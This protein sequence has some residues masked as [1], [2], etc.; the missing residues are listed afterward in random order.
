MKLHKKLKRATGITILDLT[1]RFVQHLAKKYYFPPHS[2]NLPKLAESRL[3]F[4]TS[5]KGLSQQKQTMSYT[6]CTGSKMYLFFR[7]NRFIDV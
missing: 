2:E 7:D 1:E 4:V 5:Q 3:I 6:H